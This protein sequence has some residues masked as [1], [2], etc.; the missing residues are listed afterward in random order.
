[1]RLAT[2]T[3]RTFCD[4][5]RVPNKSLTA[6]DRW[7]EDAAKNFLRQREPTVPRRV[8]PVKRNDAAKATMRVRDCD[9]NARGQERPGHGFPNT[10]RGL[11]IDR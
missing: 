9:R 1:M 4:N 11:E 3:P 7:W 10:I 8:T 6:R 2:Q 5:S